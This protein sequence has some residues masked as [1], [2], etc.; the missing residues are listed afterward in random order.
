MIYRRRLRITQY[1]QQRLLFVTLVQ[2]R[3]EAALNVIAPGGLWFL[4]LI[5]T[6]KSICEVCKMVMKG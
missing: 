6:V 4:I 3:K 5:W 1:I 2:K